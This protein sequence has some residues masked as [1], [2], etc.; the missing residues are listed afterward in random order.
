MSA[1]RRL[2]Y[3]L[4]S[5]VYDAAVGRGYVGAA[6][7]RSIE[8]LAPAPHEEL[9]IVGG[10]TGLDLCH[11]PRETALTLVDFSPRMVAQARRRAARVG[12][13][14]ARLEVAD[15]MA[16]PYASGSFDAAVLHLILAVVER[17]EDCLSEAARVL[18]P[19]GRAVVFDKFVPG[20]GEAGGVRRLLNVP[21]RFFFTDITRRL[22]E[23]IAGSPF[24]IARQEPSIFAGQFR[25][26]LL[27]R[28]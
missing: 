19:G 27:E 9:L 14:R 12:F 18:R 10:G 8:L 22:E 26:A 23:L 3:D 1:W 6:R 20:D 11:L 2:R 25:I 4:Y 5:T 15:V 13:A 28:D 21:S 17:P 16:L 24:R 7:R